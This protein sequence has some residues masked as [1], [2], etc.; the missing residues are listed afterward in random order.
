M[1]A[2][3]LWTLAMACNVYLTLF[4]HYDAK[5]LRALEWKYMVFCYGLPLIPSLAFVLIET[6]SRGKVF[7][8]AVV[9]F[10]LPSKGS[11]PTL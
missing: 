6:E 7:G 11:P 8:D 2:D 9:S 3:A 10:R 1:P 5:K 4:Y